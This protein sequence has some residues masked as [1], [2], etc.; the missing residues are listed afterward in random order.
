MLL[1]LIP[2][3]IYTMLLTKFLSL[4]KGKI[5]LIDRL[6]AAVS[7]IIGIIILGTYFGIIGISIAYVISTV[8]QVIILLYADRSILK[9]SKL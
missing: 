9:N 8:T 5:I 1:A 6:V 2:S 4:E 7:L 3:S